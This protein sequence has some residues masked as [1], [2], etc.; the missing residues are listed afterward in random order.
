MFWT[1][2]AQPQQFGDF[3]TKA[4]KEQLGRVETVQQ[5]MAKLEA[6]GFERANESIEEAAKLTR[7]SISYAHKLGA[8]WRKVSLEAMKKSTE[9]FGLGA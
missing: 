2:F 8:E 3:W 5:E 9:M 7:E 1:H 6:Q 4:M